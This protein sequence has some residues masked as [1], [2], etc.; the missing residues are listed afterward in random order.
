M[1]K[2]QKVSTKRDQSSIEEKLTN[3]QKFY[4]S[5]KNKDSIE[6]IIEYF[7]YNIFDNLKDIEYNE[8]NEDF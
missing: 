3:I 2:N 5:I 6:N 7:G 8:E 1:K 4:D